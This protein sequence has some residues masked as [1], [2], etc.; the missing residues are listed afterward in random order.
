M[1]YYARRNENAG[2][3]HWSRGAQVERYQRNFWFYLLG[4]LVS[5]V[6]SG[7]QQVAI[8]LFILDLT[9]SGT[10]MG[11][12][13]LVSNIPRI[14]FGPFAGVIGDRFNRK[15]I[16]VNMDL[17]R[18]LIILSLALMASI[19]GL[20]VGI[21]LVAQFFVS[22]LDI[23]FDP[24]TTAM[25]PDI[26]P[27]QKLTRA[28]SII[29]GVNS[30][31]YIIGPALGGV[32]YGLFG[33]RA[34]FLANG[35]SFIASAISEMFITYRQTTRRTRMTIKSTLVDIKEGLAFL[36]TVRG[37]LLLLS[38]AMLT[39]FF[40]SSAFAVVFPFFAREVVGFSSRQFGF[41]QSSWVI[42]ILLGNIILAAFLSKKS[43]DTLFKT[44]VSAQMGGFM[45]LGVIAAPLFIQILGGPS[46]IYFSVIASIFLFTGA[47]NA[48]VNTPLMT[49]FHRRTP[50]EYRSR[51]FSVIAL[52]AQMTVPLGAMLFGV[53]LDYVQVHW[54]FI[55]AATGN[56]A[57]TI[58][59]L[60]IGM[61][62]FLAPVAS[63]EVSQK[64][65]SVEPGAAAE[66]G[67]E[68]KSSA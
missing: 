22:A 20:T 11:T 7:I 24:A 23:V 38:F 33:I 36:K 15:K 29:Q 28:N 49:A 27:D 44:G 51:V 63:V 68:P 35:V 16:M 55:V 8:P 41:L 42:G 67:P 26:V 6:G 59:F 10:I 21:L 19:D 50:T 65:G 52:L 37:L 14:I 18:G 39:N 58:V 5:L 4:R 62:R 31:S 47:Y 30:V 17:A 48:L 9:G 45:L 3:S 1:I 66:P 2:R 54:L 43:P 57:A 13:V 40:I 34:V 12:F 61:S 60:S 56:A 53:A 46:W 64:T 25:I 32:L